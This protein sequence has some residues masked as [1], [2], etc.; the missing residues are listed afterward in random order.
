MSLSATNGD[1]M[2]ALE[3]FVTE[4]KVLADNSSVLKSRR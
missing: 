3:A 1:G 4:G 2:K